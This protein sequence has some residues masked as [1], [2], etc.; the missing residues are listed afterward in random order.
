MSLN[1]LVLTHS[2][3]A[4]FILIPDNTLKTVFVVIWELFLLWNSDPVLSQG[5]Q[6][7]TERKSEKEEAHVRIEK[8]EKG[9]KRKKEKPK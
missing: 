5:K 8:K 6:K 1:D 7:E 4:L 9:N 3:P 2:A